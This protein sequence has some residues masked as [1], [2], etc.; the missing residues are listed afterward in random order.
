M[1]ANLSQFDRPSKQAV[2]ANTGTRFGKMAYARCFRSEV[3]SLNYFSIAFHGAPSDLTTY[4]V[5]QANEHLIGVVTETSPGDF[6]LRCVAYCN[7]IQLKIH[8]FER[9]G[10]VTHFTFPSNTC[11]TKILIFNFNGHGILAAGRKITCTSLPK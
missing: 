10:F 8:F 1:F 6:K 2:V 7:S 4:D 5:Q 11:H 3:V 9:T